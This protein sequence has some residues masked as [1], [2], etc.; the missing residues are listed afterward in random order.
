MGTHNRDAPAPSG[1][2]GLVGA[3]PSSSSAL[4]KRA[5]K[6]DGADIPF[7][8]WG[9]TTVPCCRAPVSGE[10]GQEGGTPTS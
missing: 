6:D 1:A 10:V 7:R 4:S 8:A 5:L 9:W 3:L 2:R